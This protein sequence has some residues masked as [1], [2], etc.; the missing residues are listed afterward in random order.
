[1]LEAKKMNK[2]SNVLT[3]SL[4]SKDKI[5]GKVAK[6]L[7]KKHNY[8]KVVSTVILITCILCILIF[9]LYKR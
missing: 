1:M 3:D 9:F 6:T 8:F 5:R 2:L 4:V 7:P